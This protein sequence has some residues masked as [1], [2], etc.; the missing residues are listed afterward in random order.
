VH[1]NI[2][3]S[4]ILVPHH[5]LDYFDEDFVVKLADTGMHYMFKCAVAPSDEAIHKTV[6]DAHLHELNEYQPVLRG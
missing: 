5:I 2:S 3:P 1:G 4:N 6:D